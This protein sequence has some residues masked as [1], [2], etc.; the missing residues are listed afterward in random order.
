MS[1]SGRTLG[2][3]VNSDKYFE[4]VL[5]LAEAATAKGRQVRIL[6]L[7]KGVRLFATDEF[8]RLS[9]MAQITAGATDRG[10]LGFQETDPLPDTVTVVSAQ[11]FMDVLGEFDRTV[12][13]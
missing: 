1:E 7:G 5:K 4:Y 9:R 3:L 11:K 2:I 8:A 13:F 10:N 6:V 12:V